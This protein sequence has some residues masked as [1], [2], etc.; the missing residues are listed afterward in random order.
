MLQ[1]ASGYGEEIGKDIKIV[2]ESVLG[3]FL[4]FKYRHIHHPC[5]PEPKIF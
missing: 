5:L 3:G 2:E 1:G 4:E